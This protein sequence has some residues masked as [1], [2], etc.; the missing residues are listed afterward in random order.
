[1]TRAS[2]LIEYKFCSLYC[3]LAHIHSTSFGM[4]RAYLHIGVHE[5]LVSNG[6][7]GMLLDI[8]YQ[9]V[10]KVVMNTLVAK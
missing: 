8:T 4:L 6:T 9:C 10:A 3:A 2:K 5:H 1:M 7:C